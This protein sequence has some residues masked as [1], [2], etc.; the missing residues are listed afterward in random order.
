VKN[1]SEVWAYI[2]AHSDGSSYQIHIIEK[3]LMDQA[4]EAD[5]SRLA[6]A[7]NETGKAAVYGIYFD[8]GKSIVKPESDTAIGEI[9]KLLK[10]DAGLKLYVV[11]HT[12]NVGAFDYNVKLS[13]A[14]AASVVSALEKRYGVAGNRLT[15]F[16]VGPVSPTA[17]NKNEDGRAKNRRV[18]LVA[19]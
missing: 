2:S 8:T 4:V 3:Q 1:T 5:A 13:Q 14:R 7:I 6:A 11:G 16:G 18:E 12:D 17:S 9:A 19:Q 10:S 15:P